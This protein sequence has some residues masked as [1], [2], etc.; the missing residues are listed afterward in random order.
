MEEE[1]PMDSDSSDEDY[2]PGG[3]DNEVSEEESG[4]ESADE[5]GS[6]TEEN[7]EN[8]RKRKKPTKTK[9]RKK[10]KNSKTQEEEKE[11]EK[12]NSEVVTEEEMKK[13]S[14]SL[15]ADFMKDCGPPVKKTQSMNNETEP[16]SQPKPKSQPTPKHEPAKVTEVLTFAGEEVRIEKPAPVGEPSKTGARASTGGLSSILS[17]IGKKG[18]LSTLEKSKLDWDSFKVKEGIAED[19]ERHN[20][21][22]NGYL[23]KQDFLQRADLRQFEIEKN[24]RSATRRSLNR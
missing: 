24:M 12:E 4:N 9:K 18:K 5:L 8:S 2:V 17:Q 20:K 10:I 6:D 21:G 11:E 23:E 19:L 1:L 7:S 16:E 13:K 15:W 3:R 14:D 22:R